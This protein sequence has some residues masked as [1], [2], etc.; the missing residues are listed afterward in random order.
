MNTHLVPLSQYVKIECDLKDD[1]GE[2]LYPGAWVEVRKN[3]TNGER[4][5]LIDELEVISEEGED[6]RDLFIERATAIDAEKES[7]AS[8]ELGA[9]ERRE[10]TREIKRK[11]RELF[12][13][14][15][16]ATQ[17]L[18]KRR[19]TIIAP[20]VRGWNIYRP[21]ETP[22]PPPSVGGVDVLDEVYADFAGWLIMMCQQAYRMGKGL[23]TTNSSGD[24]QVPGQEPIVSGPQV[25]DT[26]P[27][28]RSRKKS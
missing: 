27:T 1:A 28:R 22:L 10:A 12:R 21:D 13:E 2:L 5:A 24:A 19:M 15:S 9:D 26:P 6:L 18:N 20:F 16:A 23:G 7:L 14:Q 11:A 3:L 17:E 8:A 4:I 25:I